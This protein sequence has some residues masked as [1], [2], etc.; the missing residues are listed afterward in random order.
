ML[1]GCL[2]A[3]GS[4]SL[5]Y[6]EFRVRHAQSLVEVDSVLADRNLGPEEAQRGRLG[7]LRS[8]LLDR[9][10]SSGQSPYTDLLATSPGYC[11]VLS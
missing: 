10:L 2:L 3:P 4:G 5:D 9:D 11:G 7:D 6:R 1:A 8:E